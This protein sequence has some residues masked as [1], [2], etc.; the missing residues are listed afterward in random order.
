[1]KTQ[2]VHTHTLTLS[3][4]LSLSLSL[5]LTHTHTHTRI[6]TYSINKGEP[7]SNYT[8]NAF[9]PNPPTLPTAESVNA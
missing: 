1:M 9:L 8:T 4:T 5:S 2:H 6:H 3:H 7:S